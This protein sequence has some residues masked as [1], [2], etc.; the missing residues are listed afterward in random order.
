LANVSIITIGDELLIGQVIDTNSAFIAQLLN[1]NGFAVTRRVAVGDNYEAIEH[2]LTE[3]KN[4]AEIILITGGL[5]P[6]ADDITKPLLN[7]YFGGKMVVNEE[8]YENV[9]HIFEDILKRPFTE[10]NKKQA[11]VPDVCTVIQNKRG[12]APGMV[13]YEGNKTFVSMPGVPAEM[14]AMMENDVVPLLL[15][16]Y[17]PATIQ[18]KTLLLAGIGESM[19]A[20]M[21]VDFE[22]EINKSNIKLAYLPNYGFLRL[23][24]TAVFENDAANEALL[25]DKFVQLQQIVKQYLVSDTDEPIEKL[26]FNTLKSAGKTLTTA[27]SCTGGYIAQLITAQAGA[28]AIFNSGI[29][30]YSNEAK[31][32]LLHVNADTLLQKGA[33]SEQTVVE[34]ATNSLNIAKADYGIAVSG[35]MGPTGGSEEKPVGTVWICVASTKSHKAHKVN[36][37]FNRETNIRLT[38]QHALHFL[39][40][41]IR[42][43]V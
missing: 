33:V 4:K 2:A 42:S 31:I 34:M 8:V 23:R 24:L 6:T 28:S 22:E 12:T 27:E 5:G 41:L 3:E 30:S 19:V 1:K 7:K 18:H 17:K 11:E 29:V 38:A 39:L 35:I 37:R 10:R 21:L 9:R 43:E 32:A 16:K 26:V 14:K 36:L 13:F 20:D 40:M 25:Q 15:K